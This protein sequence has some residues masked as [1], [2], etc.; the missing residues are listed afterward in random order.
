MGTTKGTV[1]TLYEKRGVS[2]SKA[3]VHQ[4]IEKLDKGIFPN[5]FCKILPDYLGNSP[6]YCNISHS[7]GAGTK[8]SLAYA[9]WKETGDL[10]VFEG[11]AKDAL[12]MNL[13]D[14]LCAGVTNEPII[15]TSTIGRNKNLVSGEAIKAIIE[16]TQNCIN[17]LNEFGINIHFAGGETAD[18]GDLV[19]TLIVDGSMTTRMKRSRIMVPNILPGDVIIG[20]SSYGKATYESEANSGI[21]SNGLTSARHDLFNKD[22]GKRY[23]ETYDHA[24]KRK[25]SYCGKYNLTDIISIPMDTPSLKLFS[26][27]KVGKAVLSPTRTYAPVIMEIMKNVKRKYISAII[28]CSGGGQTK[29]MN[30]MSDAVQIRKEFRN[31][32]D[33]FKMIQN[34]SN[35]SWNEMCRTFNMGYRMEIYCRPYAAKAIIDSARKFNVIAHKIGHVQERTEK[36]KLS[37]TSHFGTVQY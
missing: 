3:E 32:P 16:G 15:Y 12:V 18:V 36:W 17:E 26:E 14:M 1:K 5:A 27:V 22:V 34:A 11:I 37:I 2:S 13:D 19:R 24:M 8:S 21:G 25:Y 10:S 9:Y 31:T 20:L 28:H 23:P 35:V 30:F 33:F 29:V 6:K 7:D 4:A